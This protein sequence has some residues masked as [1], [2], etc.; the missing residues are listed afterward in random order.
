LPRSLTVLAR[1][2]D[3][4]LLPRCGRLGRA[5][6][7]NLSVNSAFFAANIRQQKTP[8][9]LALGSVLLLQF[10]PARFS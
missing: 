1:G 5:C 8:E 6:S 3:A 9:G 7:A 2:S 10:Q 4:F